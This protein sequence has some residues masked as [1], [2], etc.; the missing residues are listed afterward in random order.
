M[1]RI[2][3]LA[4]I[5]PLAAAASAPLQTAPDPAGV[6]LENAMA[7][8]ASA[9]A[10]AKRLEALA[11][12]ARGEAER[13]RAQ[14]AAAAQGIEAAEA[15]ITAADVR[16]R[17]AAARAA[18][19]RAELQRRQRP[20]SSLLAGLVMMSQRPPLLALAD[21]G[22]T[23]EFVRVRVLLDST[24]P[25]IRAR[26]SAISARLS[27]G[28][29][30]EQAALAARRELVESRKALQ[31]RRQAFA[32]FEQ[33]ALRM[34]A[35]AG[36][37]A[38]S[39]GDVALAAGE[40]AE[41]LRGARADARSAR[42]VAAE[43]AATDPAPPRPAPPE[44]QRP[45]APFAYR[46]PAAAPVVDGL[47][48]VDSSGIRSRGITLATGRGTQLIVPASGVVRFSG[49]FRSHDGIVII[50]HGRGWIS[51]IVNVA[52]PLRPGA[53]VSAGEP[54]GRALGPIEVELSQNGRHISPALI[55][56]SSQ[57]L[58]KGGEGG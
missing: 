25:V 47:G 28:E 46:L 5:L 56:G 21:E 27:E 41:V 32:S 20:V 58:S 43:L 48:S 4:L 23:D 55:A 2:A 7:E 35:S 11:G 34:A 53:R 9:E 42:Q 54:L 6:A 18:A 1:R 44:G 10:R 39:A 17:I 50:D 12:R 36:G 8:Q 29:R 22:S 26:T 15:R 33:R 13:L 16:L 24:L 52:S 38:L 45:S 14:Q 51:L 3:T 57:T 19:S 31:S 37:Q 30:L 40:Q 49:P